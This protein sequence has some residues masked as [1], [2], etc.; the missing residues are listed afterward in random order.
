MNTLK[1]R[2]FPRTASWFFGAMLIFIAT[3]TTA[4]ASGEPTT[5]SGPVRLEDPLQGALKGQG[6]LGVAINVAN[7]LLGM[8]GALGVAVV[9]YGG[10]LLL[11]SGGSQERIEKGK[12]AI[13]WAVIGIA[14]A[15]FSYIILQFI[16]NAARGTAA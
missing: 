12:A 16:I 13:I 5:G 14:L 10:V 11:T 3:S 7:V 2:I 8:I 15:L 9:I 1:K 6:L 4:I